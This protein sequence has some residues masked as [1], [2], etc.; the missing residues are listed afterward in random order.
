M[1]F[2]RF[3]NC[4]LQVHTPADRQ[5]LYGN[6][7]GREPNQSFARTLME[8]H[9]NVGV[10]VIAVTDHNRVDW[11]PALS[12]AGQEYGVSVFPGLE[13][14]VNGCHLLL[15][16]D[17]SQEGYELAQRFL[18]TLWPPGE[19]PFYENGDPKPVALGQVLEVAGRAAEHRAL[20]LAPHTTAKGIGIFA[21]GVC[22]NHVEV[23]QS[24]FVLGFDVMGDKQADVLKNPKAVFGNVPPSW[25]ISG[26]VR[27]LDQVGRRTMYLKL[28]PAPTL[29]G[30]R[31]AFLMPDTR[32]RFP[33]ILQSEWAHVSGAQ[34]LAS[35][36]PSWPRIES[37]KIEGGFH[38]GLSA[39]IAPGLN[40]LIGGKGTGKSTLI[41]IIRYVLDGGEPIVVDGHS[42]RRS[43]FRANAEAWIGIVN[44]QDEPYTIHRSG[45]ESPARLLRDGH[46]TE[47]D[48]RRRFEVTVFGQRE[49]QELA[50]RTELLREFVASQVGAKWESALKIESEI[51]SGLQSAERELSQIESDLE[52]MQEFLDELGDIRE[53]LLRAQDRGAENLVEESNTLAELDRAVTE[54]FDWPDKVSAAVNHLEGTLP[55]PTVASHHL[56]PQDLAGHISQ[57]EATVTR[58]VGELRSAIDSTAA[59]KEAR[60]AE[61]KNSHQ[62]ER[63]RIQSEL[64]EAG[65]AN[66]DELDSLQRRRASLTNLVNNQEGAVNRKS[67]LTGQRKEQLM[68]LAEIRRRKSRLTEEA[69]RELTASVGERIRVR[70]DPLADR[71]KLLALFDEHLRGQAVRRAQLERL[72][73]SSPS[74]IAEAMLAGPKFLA[75]LGCSAATAAKLAELPTSVVRACEECDI[76][77]RVTVEI[78]LGGE[79]AENWVSVQEVSPGQRATALLALALVSGKS[80]LIIDQPEDDLDNRYIYDE[81]V[82]VLRTVCN[83]R[84][85]IVATHNA[86]VAVLGDAELV[87]ALD[88]DS[89]QGKLLALGGLESPSV[90]ETTRRI[91][92]G[93]DEA[94]RAR[95]RRYLASESS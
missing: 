12:E 11:Y 60:S 42:N 93:G 55:A 33:Q 44:A 21:K 90:A 64:A 84:Q 35:P 39:E 41:E 94:F 45:D 38:S 67:Q 47:V 68:A 69:A 86:N 92:E 32:L 27:S 7:G 53:R 81:V 46:D 74:V 43:N 71:S 87:L 62:S 51:V 3:H 15:L 20:V 9:A 56:L 24:G 8:A 18:Q 31:Q 52:R 30:I 57:L 14:S 23:A 36:R 28:S 63:H 16:W 10:E 88:A 65:I 49:L 76:P 77:D 95:H 91:L 73:E 19:L 37:V 85:V 1:A 50:S 26:D 59:E 48:V 25:F 54:V 78:N 2:S 6:V 29:E 40:A 72:V 17:R 70:T 13:V 83:A 58:A 75:A 61:W 82:K 22:R 66:P 34:F 89:G 5:Q 4:D 79:G 80:P